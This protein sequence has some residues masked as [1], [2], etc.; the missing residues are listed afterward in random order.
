M[1][2]VIAVKLSEGEDT[3]SIKNYFVAQYGP[4]VLGEPP[5]EG[6]NWLAWALPVLALV[7][8]GFFVWSRTRHMMRTAEPAMPA[9]TGE[10]GSSASGDAY[11]R[12][13]EEELKQYD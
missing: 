11:K 4:Q 13:L 8:G 1:K 5:M 10:A 6:F 7:A 9:V 2:D 12:K 3:Q